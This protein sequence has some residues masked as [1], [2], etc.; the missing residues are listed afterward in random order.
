ML[1]TGRNRSF[2]TRLRHYAMIGRDTRDDALELCRA[3]TAAGGVC[4]VKKS[5]AP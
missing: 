2:G 1:L 4:L 3:L 5:S